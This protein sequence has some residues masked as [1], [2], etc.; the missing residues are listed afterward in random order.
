MHIRTSFGV[1]LLFFFVMGL[2]LIV[3]YRTQVAEREEAQ[4]ILEAGMVDEGMPLRLG[5]RRVNVSSAPSSATTS[6]QAE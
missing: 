2:F 4:A 3:Q 6:E 1:L 5:K